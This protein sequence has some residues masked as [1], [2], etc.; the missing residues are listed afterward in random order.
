MARAKNY[1]NQKSWLFILMHGFLAL[2]MK[3]SELTQ[4]P[5]QIPSFVI[6]SYHLKL[7][8]ATV[9]SR[10]SVEPVV[11]YFCSK[12]Q[13]V[14]IYL[15]LV[16]TNMFLQS[17]RCL[18]RFYQYIILGCPCTYVSIRLKPILIQEQLVSWTRDLSECCGEGA[19]G[20]R[21]SRKKKKK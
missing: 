14:S 9:C 10:A 8:S 16:K 7:P 2:L 17:W 11:S 4:C 6:T 15:N 13:D 5:G 18:T 19:W 21:K 1:Q 20:K 12:W 3:N